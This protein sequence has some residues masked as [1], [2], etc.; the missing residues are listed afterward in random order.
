M[1]VPTAAP[2][3][4]AT[5]SARH[6][7]RGGRRRGFF[8][9]LVGVVGELLITAGLFLG[10]FVVWQ[11]FWTSLEVQPGM[12]ARIEDFQMTFPVGQ[13]QSV[14]E[15]RKDAPPIIDQPAYG[16]TFGVLH[17]PKWDWMQIPIIEGTGQEILD[18]G[19]A[20]HYEL[21][22]LP[23]EVGNFALA[24]HRRTYGNNFRRVDILEPGDPIVVETENA[25]IVYKVT[26]K[27]IVLPSQTEVLLPVPNQLGVI[28]T[29]RIM[30]MTTCHPEFGN[31]HRYIVYSEFAYW[32]DKAEGKPK[33]LHDEPSR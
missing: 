9:G 33:I 28:P 16:Q 26:E 6:Q 24:G 20:G 15:E 22:Q 10:L 1:T 32:T 2:A 4:P 7:D 19:N 21:T 25:F 5:R 29:K 23:G 14:P 31:S 12:N 8:S 11:L 3:A 17:V 18:L 13:E 30:T 27:E